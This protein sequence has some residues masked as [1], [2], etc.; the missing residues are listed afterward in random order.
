L[1]I[2]TCV[3]GVAAGAQGGGAGA[4]MLAV[5]AEVSIRYPERPC[6]P[7]TDASFQCFARVGTAG[8]SGLGT[9]EE[10]YDYVLEN[11]PAGCTAPQGADSVRLPATTARLVVAGK[12]VVEVSTSGTG[13]LARFGSL[14]ASEA[15]TITGGSGRYA[16]ASG[17][18][19]VVTTSFG[20]PN[21]SGSDTWTGTLVVAGLQFDLTAP[22]IN[23]AVGKMV[24]VA[25]FAKRVR[26]TYTA[27]AKDDVDG[28]VP[29]M[30]LPR[31]GSWFAV[32]LTSVAC[33]A[34]DTSANTSK[35][36]FSVNVK[37]RR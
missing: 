22:A 31:S 24:R 28:D 27:T 5:H 10:S 36:R 12:G 19:T 34:T 21:F 14:Q 18:G 9:V 29:V 11:N 6:P 26:V 7:S 35:V 25:R 30:C 33:S 20:P 8:I 32:G 23:G 17:G 15:F 2:A 16:G 1:T 4:E 37:R 3:G 13:C